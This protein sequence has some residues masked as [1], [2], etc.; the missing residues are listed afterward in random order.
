MIVTALSLTKI[1][2]GSRGDIQV[3]ADG[4][5]DIQR[6]GTVCRLNTAHVSPADIDL[7]GKFALRIAA[8]FAIIGDIETKEFV[9]ISVLCLHVRASCPND[10]STICLV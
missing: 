6:D 8:C 5:D 1:E 3:I 2:Q 9:F 4:K 10:R 7:L